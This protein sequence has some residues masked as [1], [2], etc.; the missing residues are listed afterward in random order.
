MAFTEVSSLLHGSGSPH[1]T[2]ELCRLIADLRQ[3][4]YT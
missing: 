1:G 3:L 2:S 4:P